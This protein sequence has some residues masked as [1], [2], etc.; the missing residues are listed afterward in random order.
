MILMQ[1]GELAVNGLDNDA[2]SGTALIFQ[3]CIQGSFGAAKTPRR[4][5]PSQH[6]PVNNN[7]YQNIE[8]PIGEDNPHTVQWCGNA[9]LEGH[10]GLWRWFADQHLQI[11]NR[12]TIAAPV[13]FNCISQLCFQLYFS[14]QVRGRW[15]WSASADQQEDDH[16]C[17]SLI[18]RPLQWPSLSDLTIIEMTI[19]KDLSNLCPL[20]WIKNIHSLR[21]K[22]AG[23]YFHPCDSKDVW[24]VLVLQGFSWF[25][26]LRD[27]LVMGCDNDDKFNDK[28]WGMTEVFTTGSERCSVRRGGLLLPTLSYIRRTWGWWWWGWLV[29][30]GRT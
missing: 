12:M 28:N 18:Q 26:W 30:R 4:K 29:R 19:S 7:P 6:Q 24:F 20:R 15:R 25:I 23:F 5:E 1:A 21:R 3:S 14:T 17:A 11:S 10:Q 8:I 13:W 16:C 22:E 27:L 2:L 9:L